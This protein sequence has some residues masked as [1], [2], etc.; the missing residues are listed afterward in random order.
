MF[1]TTQY[2]RD[3]DYTLWEPILTS[4]YHGM[5]WKR[6]ISLIR[7]ELA[8]CL[9]SFLG[10]FDKEMREASRSELTVV[11]GFRC[12]QTMERCIPLSK[13]FI[14]PIHLEYIY[15]YIR[16]VLYMDYKPLTKWDAHPSM[17]SIFQ[18]KRWPNPIWHL[19]GNR[20]EATNPICFFVNY[21]VCLV[22]GQGLSKDSSPIISTAWTKIIAI[23]PR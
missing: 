8:R 18:W 2:I 16:V 1:F 15:I 17:E 9:T 21:Y 13:W 7:S 11:G 20:L 14:A 5:T 23:Q 4:K 10:R 6:V 12:E 22:Q 19:R 3:C